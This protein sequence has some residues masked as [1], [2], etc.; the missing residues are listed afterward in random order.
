MK[1][2]AGLFAG[3]GGLE[4]GLH[5]AGFVSTMMCEIDRSAQHV[6]RAQFP[7]V[8]IVSDVR[9]VDQV[10]SADVLCAGFPCQ[11]LSSVGQKSGIGGR[12]SSLVEEVFRILAQNE[13]DWVVVEN[14]KFM[15]HLNKG[16]AM[17]RVVEGFEKLGY[18][19][20]Y[21][22]VNSLA[23]GVPQRRHRVFFVASKTGD[24]REVLLSDDFGAPAEHDEIPS[25]DDHIGFY[26]TEG[27]YAAGLSRNS[28]PPLKAGST[29]GIPSPPAI[30][31][32]HGLVGTPDLR[33]AERMQGFDADWTLPAEECGR[34]SLRWRLLG[35]AVTVPV[36][37][38]V[39]ERLQLPQP[40]DS[41]QDLPLKGK[42]PAAAWSM[43]N[44]R[45]EAKCTEWPRGQQLVHIG[46]FLRY[47]PK[48]LSER[49][50]KGFLSRAFKGNLKFPPGFLDALTSHMKRL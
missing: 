9:A 20:A 39:G 24:P 33:D 46:D 43:G 12:Q 38:W 3:I 28:I 14:V 30:L 48:A 7:G 23:F 18:R 4:L 27:A 49:A 25:L 17:T 47:E 19:W 26:W 21:R 37:E 6:L 2:V 29:I 13:I 41:S 22:V 1:K 45:Y 36:A 32:P 50:T 15:L 44:G 34:A 8:E 40:Y 42:W 5:R 35:N 11:D 10:R 31:F 16:E